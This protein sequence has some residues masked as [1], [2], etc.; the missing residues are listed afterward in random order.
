MLILRLLLL[1]I[2]IGTG[3]IG[4]AESK[5]IDNV[6][7]RDFRFKTVHNL[8]KQC[9][10]V[11]PVAKKIDESVFLQRYWPK[12]KV[13]YSIY[14]SQILVLS[15][16]QSDL[17]CQYLKYGRSILLGLPGYTISYPFHSFP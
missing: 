15:D 11:L 13:D 16:L 12:P 1:V 10:L 6:P 9:G 14:R 7:A 5:T 17:C 2:F 8:H 4:I 3:T